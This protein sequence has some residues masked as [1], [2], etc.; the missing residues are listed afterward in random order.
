M[1]KNGA[2]VMMITMLMMTTMPMTGV[3]TIGATI[4]V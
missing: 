4:W 3:T 1:T 2:G